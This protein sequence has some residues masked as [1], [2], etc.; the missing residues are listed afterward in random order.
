[1]HLEIHM[2]TFKGREKPIEILVGLKFGKRYKVNFTLELG[3]LPLNSVQSHLAQRI[4]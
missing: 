4:G 3:N 2:K 1:M